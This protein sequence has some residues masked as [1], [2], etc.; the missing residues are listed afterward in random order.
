MK[1]GL[2]IQPSGAVLNGAAH[3]V[4]IYTSE[5]LGKSK[6]YIFAHRGELKIC[7][8]VETA[9]KKPFRI[10]KN[11]GHHGTW[12]NLNEKKINAMGY[13]AVWY[14]GGGYLRGQETITYNEGQTRLWGFFVL[15]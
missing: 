5:W 12:F 6:N 14:P 10:G 15:K 13:D 7:F 4:G 2:K 8:I 1:N 11:Q 9:Y 3:G